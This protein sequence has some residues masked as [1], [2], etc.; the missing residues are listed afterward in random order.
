MGLL[1]AANHRLLRALPLCR[2]LP[3][4]F[5]GMLRKRIDDIRHP[6]LTGAKDG[7]ARAELLP[8]DGDLLLPQDGIFSHRATLGHRGEGIEHGLHGSAA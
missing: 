8:I 3:S 7:R 2:A 5:G 4:A 1:G 6:L